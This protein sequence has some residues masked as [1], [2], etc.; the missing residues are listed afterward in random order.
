MTADA[1]R[2]RSHW[3]PRPGWHPGRD[4]YTWHITFDDAPEL[5]RLAE[6]YQTQLRPLSGLNLVPIEW[7]HLTVQG[8]GFADE[9]SD[10]ALHAVT[11][12]VQKSVR[13]LGAFP[14]TFDAPVIFDEAIV[15]PPT[16]VEP[17]QDLLTAIRSGI[18]DALGP[19]SVQTGPEQARGFRPHV[20]LA[21]SS[22][23]H[24]SAP[25]R[26]ALDAADA[27][28]ATVQISAPAL[29]R[30]ERLLAP[31]WLYRWTTEARAPL[32]A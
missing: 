20:S 13:T 2:T 31:E 27:E 17:F 30:Q 9:V 32:A 25:Y 29:I 18:A 3:W 22:G 11:A 16:P 5:H 24:D 10:D 26:Q 4:V 21:Y 12:S 14:A 7:L 8:V 19:D 6:Q 15:L 28:P 1:P 23:E